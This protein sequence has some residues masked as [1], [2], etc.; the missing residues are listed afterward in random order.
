[1]TGERAR[2][3]CILGIGERGCYDVPCRAKAVR[4]DGGRSGEQVSAADQTRVVVTADPPQIHL[5]P[6]E[7]QV[8]LVPAREIAAGTTMVGD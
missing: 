8:V 7:Q 5:A 2:A 3:A 1:V 4:A 6:D